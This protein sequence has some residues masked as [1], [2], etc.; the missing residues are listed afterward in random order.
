MCVCAC[1]YIYLCM[2]MYIVCGRRCNKLYT[3]T[4]T[5]ECMYVYIYIYIYIY[6]YFVYK[7]MYVHYTHIIL[8]YVMILY[9]C[10]FDY[11]RYYRIF[12]TNIAH[13]K[14]EYY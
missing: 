3:C 9:S 10:G 13:I 8:F 11:A 12:Y 5:G 4:Q 1:V 2:C 14:I 6:I 7:Y